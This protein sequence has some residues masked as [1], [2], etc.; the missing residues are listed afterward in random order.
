M[1][2]LESHLNTKQLLKDLPKR[3]G[4]V[5]PLSMIAIKQLKRQEMRYQ[6]S[7]VLKTYP[8]FGH[9]KHH[10]IPPWNPKLASWYPFAPPK[11][12]DFSYLFPTIQGTHLLPAQDEGLSMA[13]LQELWISAKNNT[14]GWFFLGVICLP[15]PWKGKKIRP[16]WWCGVDI[17]VVFVIEWNL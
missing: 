7:K 11:I 14:L 13:E 1:P 15:S 8:Q 3:K 17:W 4:E 6:S 9:N 10:F 12:H 5:K 2:F 16:W